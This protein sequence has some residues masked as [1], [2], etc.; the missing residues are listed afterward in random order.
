MSL[1]PDSSFHRDYEP[2]E[3]EAI[4]EGATAVGLSLNRSRTFGSS[5]VDVPLNDTAYWKQIPKKIWEYTASGYTVLKKWI[6]YREAD[7]LGRGSVKKK[8]ESSGISLADYGPSPPRAGVG[9][10]V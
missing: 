1:G 2:D 6:S 8:R 5:T 3:I 7:V 9:R 10:N 4:K